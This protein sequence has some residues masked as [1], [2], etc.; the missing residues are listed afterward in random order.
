LNVRFST[1]H[2]FGWLVVGVYIDEDH[3]LSSDSDRISDNLFSC[4]LWHFMSCEET[5]Y[6]VEAIW[7]SKSLGISFHE[8]RRVSKG[9]QTRHCE[10]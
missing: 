10:K 9:F 4:L 7:L 2:G 6:Y 1:Q 5:C 8:S 3:F